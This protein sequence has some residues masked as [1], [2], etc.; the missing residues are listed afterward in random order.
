MDLAKIRKKSLLPPPD[1]DD[2]T[3]AGPV[4]SS[5]VT[6]F[7]HDPIP[8]VSSQPPAVA[9][10]QEPYSP[11]LTCESWAG[12]SPRTERI[13][14]SGTPLEILLAGRSA[15]GCDDDSLIS[16][17]DSGLLYS[18]PGLEFLSFRISDEI[19]GIN[20]MDIKEIIKPREVT[21]V[22]RAPA[23]V[24]G[25]ISLRGVIIPVIDMKIRLNLARK[26]Y[27]G[28]ERIIVIKNRT[29][30]C[31]LQVDEVIQVV[32]IQLDAVEA[33]PH[34]LDGI[35]RDF[36]SGLGRSDGRFIIILNLENVADINLY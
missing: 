15:V 30:F 13:A 26:E 11:A 25:I 35:D 33:A 28:K 2:I 7:T 6:H 8:V 3:S 1:T 20:I 5:G 16:E 36:V 31:G 14:P 18:N 29:S 19:Y 12:L 24:S 27:S 22:P 34:V 17:N 9:L 21:E 32:K 10:C 23:F 4:A